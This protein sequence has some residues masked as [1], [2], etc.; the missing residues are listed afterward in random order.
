M[1]TRR[2]KPKLVDRL[3]A[4]LEVL[5]SAPW[6]KLVKPLI[7][8]ALSTGPISFADKVPVNPKI[9]Q[10]V[11]WLAIMTMVIGSGLSCVVTIP[12]YGAPRRAPGYISAIV[13]VASLV[14]LLAITGQVI[15]LDPTYAAFLVRLL[16]IG[17]FAGFAG[18]AAFLLTWALLR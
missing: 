4:L 11:W 10:D 2:Q 3:L 7:I 14:A 12:N 5:Q 15:V 6:S 17:V 18:F 13:F 8:M 9:I 16:L 1:P